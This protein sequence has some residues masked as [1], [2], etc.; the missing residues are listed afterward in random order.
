M[1]C[2]TGLASLL[3]CLP[4]LERLALRPAFDPGPCSIANDGLHALSCLLRL[5]ELRLHGWIIQVRACVY[6]HR[7]G[8]G[9]VA[10]DR[11]ATPL[12]QVPQALTARKV[13]LQIPCSCA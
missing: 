4:Q 7:A 1:V 6:M 2:P 8:E 3:R 10:C 13:A 12:V 9:G 11:M 5:Q